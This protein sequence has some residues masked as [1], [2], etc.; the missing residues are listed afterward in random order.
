MRLRF[1]VVCGLAFC[2]CAA[3]Q[4]TLL[5]SIRGAATASVDS[6]AI[7]IELPDLQRSVQRNLT[8]TYSLP[9]TLIVE[10]PEA[11]TT[12]VVRVT[13][14][15]PGGAPLSASA[16]T[17]S[18]PHRQTSLDLVLGADAT[19]GGAGDGEA[20]DLA[21]SGDLGPNDLASP[22]DLITPGATWHVLVPPATPGVRSSAKIVYDS[23]RNQTILFGGNTATSETNATWIWNNT[24]W[25]KATPATS[26][27]A[28]RGFG[29]AYDSARHVTVLFGGIGAAE[30]NETWEWDGTNWAQKTTNNLAGTPW[31]VRSTALAYHAA[32]GKT[33]L[34]GG[35]SGTHNDNPPETWE[36]DGATWTKQ[37]P[38][39]TPPPDNA[40][41]L[42]YDSARQVVIYVSGRAPGTNISTWE[43]SA[44]GQWTQR[45]TAVAP[46]RRRTPSLA[47]DS[48]RGVSVLF[49]GLGAGNLDLADTW[50]WNGATWTQR[51]VAIP[52]PVR[53]ST[54]MT[55]DTTAGHT[56][57]FGGAAGLFNGSVNN[58]P[59]TFLG[60]TW[61][62]Y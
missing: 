41:A 60:D 55:F 38:T 28:R 61:A 59:I 11:A 39:T 16:S 42:V 51:F 36:W 40:H 35:Y 8:G 14:T 43:Y 10:L 48:V 6:P 52:P 1:I 53:R 50:E 54:A 20:P 21:V 15:G 33:V 12:V 57:L 24:T 26:P 44:A 3:D 2:A 13:A 46:P 19:D 17:T 30:Y 9:Q 34:F 22:P 27:S 56:V 45:T 29:L 62:L 25:T 37:T 4:T 5:V 32:R 7:D 18:V 23:F 49:G 58:G 47:Y 31:P